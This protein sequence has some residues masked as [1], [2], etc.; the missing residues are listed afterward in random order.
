MTDDWS[1][2]WMWM[3]SSLCCGSE[4]DEWWVNGWWRLV[5]THPSLM[6]FISF[7]Y[8]SHSIHIPFHPFT[9]SLILPFLITPSYQHSF[10]FHSSLF[11]F[12]SL[13]S[14]TP[15]TLSLSLSLWWMRCELFHPF[16]HSL[17]ILILHCHFFHPFYYQLT[18]FT[19]YSFHF[20]TLILMS[21]HFIHL[22]LFIIT[23]II[24]WLSLTHLSCHSCSFSIPFYHSISFYSLSYTPYSSPLYTL[25]TQHSRFYPFTIYTI[26]STLSSHFIHVL[27]NTL[28]Y[29][30]FIQYIITQNTLSL[31]IYYTHLVFIFVI[32]LYSILLITVSTPLHSIQTILSSRTLSHI[33]YTLQQSLSIILF[34]HLSLTLLSIYSHFILFI[35]KHL[36]L[37]LSYTLYYSLIYTLHFFYHSQTIITIHF[38]NIILVISHTHIHIIILTIHIHS[39]TIISLSHSDSLHHHSH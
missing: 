33:T 34:W 31:S 11:H 10:S 9:F 25:C 23:S 17:F 6:S 14:L 28:Y 15:F 32:I 13:L 39:H 3:E 5:N 27:F 19:S 29:T 35:H 30:L 16:T 21:Y 20:I 7:F 8:H 12:Y 24:T 2:R 18:S 26:H 22:S 36:L 4:T 1:C 38:T 37:F